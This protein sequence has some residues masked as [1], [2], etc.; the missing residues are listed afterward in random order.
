ML[1]R[2]DIVQRGDG[3][4][5]YNSGNTKGILRCENH[6]EKGLLIIEAAEPFTLQ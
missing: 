6:R 2:T 1:L 4:Y 5:L 3:W